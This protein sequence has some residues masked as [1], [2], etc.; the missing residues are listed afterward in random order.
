MQE[1]N[2]LVD[3]RQTVGALFGLLGAFDLVLAMRLH[4]IVMS[5]VMR[6]PCVGIS[7]DPKVER[8]LELTGQPN[9]GSVASLEEE[10]LYRVLLDTWERRQGIAAH[11]DKVFAHLRQQA[12]ETASLTLSVFYARSPQKR[13]E[14]GRTGKRAGPGHPLQRAGRPPVPA[15]PERRCGERQRTKART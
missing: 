6:V 15:P 8:F 4:A 14:L 9:A 11:L 12:W 3:R 1:P 13:R 5:S 7:Y 2:L 10:Q